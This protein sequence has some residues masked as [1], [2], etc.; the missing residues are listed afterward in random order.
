MRG[1]TANMEKALRSDGDSLE[2]DRK[3]SGTPSQLFDI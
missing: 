2:R 3:V 1:T